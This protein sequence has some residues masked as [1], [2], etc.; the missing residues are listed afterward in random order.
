MHEYPG[1]RYKNK[2]LWTQEWSERWFVMLEKY[3]EKVIVEIVGHDHYGDF[4]YH[5]LDGN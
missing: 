1:V 2:M 3:R 5:K 4:R